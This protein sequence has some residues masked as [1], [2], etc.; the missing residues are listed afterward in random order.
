M[1]FFVVGASGL[2]G[3]NFVNHLKEQGHDAVGTHLTLE[4]PDT[5]FFD[6]VDI[7]NPKNYDLSVFKPDVIVHCA[8]LANV[9]YCITKLNRSE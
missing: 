2:V 5:V 4:T 6:A 8:A 3:S 1:K 7:N 9:D